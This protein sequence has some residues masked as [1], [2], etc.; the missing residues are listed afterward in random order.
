M[1]ARPRRE[2]PRALVR[3]PARVRVLVVPGV[4]PGRK[5]LFTVAGCTGYGMDGRLRA[6]QAAA[7]VGAGE[8]A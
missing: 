5:A 8:P 3:A 4:V 2:P 7:S 1:S 6:S